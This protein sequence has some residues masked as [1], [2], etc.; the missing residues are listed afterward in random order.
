MEDKASKD[1]PKNRNAP[2][3]AFK[4]RLKEIGIEIFIIVFSI[5]LS[6]SLDNWNEDRLEKKKAKEFL[7]EI[8]EDLKND[9][10]LMEKNK[11]KSARLAADSKFILSLKK[12]QYRDETIG[13]HTSIETLSS[14][15]NVARYEGFK[16]SG[17]IST[18]EN[19]KL[20]NNLLTYYQQTLP[21]LVFKANFLFNEHSKILVAV[22]DAEEDAT[23]NEIYTKRRI[24]GM[25]NFVGVNYGYAVNAYEKA[26]AQANQIIAEIEKE[27]KG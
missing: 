18:I 5:L 2:K 15:F 25:F 4:S 9:V 1:T 16:S 7:I 13:P 21:D 27:T 11:S 26:I 8:V 6:L 12:N 17:K 10:L 23:L 24:K 3:S 22:G 20:K 19:V 14:N